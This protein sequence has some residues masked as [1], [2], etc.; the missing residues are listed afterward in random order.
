MTPLGIAMYFHEGSIVH[1]GDPNWDQEYADKFN[2]A[3]G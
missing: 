1:P 3:V 2:A